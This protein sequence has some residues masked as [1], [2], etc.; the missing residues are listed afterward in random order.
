MRQGSFFFTTQDNCAWSQTTCGVALLCGGVGLFLHASR[1]GVTIH[2]TIKAGLNESTLKSARLKRNFSLILGSFLF[3]FCLVLINSERDVR[4]S[5]FAIFIG[6][7]GIYVG[8]RAIPKARR[9][10]L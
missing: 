6:L 5:L 10:L 2:Q 8:I 7:R 3:L 9:Q 1:S 4:V